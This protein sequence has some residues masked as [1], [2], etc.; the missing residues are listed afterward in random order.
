MAEASLIAVLESVLGPVWVWLVLGENPGALSVAGGV[1][2]LAALAGH[3]VADL[4]IARAATA[5]TAQSGSGSR[6]LSS[7]GT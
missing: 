4:R 6:N 5:A 7:T 2:V 3:T 1:L